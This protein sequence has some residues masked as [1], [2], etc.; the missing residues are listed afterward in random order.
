L[1]PSHHEHPDH[2]PRVCTLFVGPLVQNLAHF[3]L[4]LV[5]QSGRDQRHLKPPN[6]TPTHPNSSHYQNDVIGEF[7][8]GGSGVENHRKVVHSFVRA[9]ILQRQDQREF[10]PQP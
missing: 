4:H 9:H 5:R 6:S 3:G 2:L 7:V 1:P 10:G 8:D